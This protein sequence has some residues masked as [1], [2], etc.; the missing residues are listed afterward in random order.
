MSRPTFK[1]WL[2]HEAKYRADD[3]GTASR[4][5]VGD[6]CLTARSIAGIV[7]HRE[8]VHNADVDEIDAIQRAGG[9]WATTMRR[10]SK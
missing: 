8:N 3:V 1:T 7:E 9:E 2:L 10:R 6:S 4:T 5:L